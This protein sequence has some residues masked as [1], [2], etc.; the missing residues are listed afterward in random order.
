ME[1][2]LLWAPLIYAA[3]RRKLSLLRIARNFPYVYLNKVINIHYAWKA[4]VVELIGVPLNLTAG[5]TAYVKGR[6]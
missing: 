5:L 1:I 6:A 3:R 2:V 4:M